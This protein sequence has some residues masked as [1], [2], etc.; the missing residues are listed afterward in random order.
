M[1]WA[2]AVAMER[3]RRARR[4]KRGFILLGYGSHRWL[5]RDALLQ[6][7]KAADGDKGDGQK[8]PQRGQRGAAKDG[9]DRGHRGRPL[10]VAPC[11]GVQR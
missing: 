3:A 8:R 4:V 9:R 5:R 1:D 7:K 11:I 6:P 10:M 2:K